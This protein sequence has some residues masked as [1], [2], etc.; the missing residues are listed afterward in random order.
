ML[1]NTYKIPN[2]QSTTKEKPII[3][4][5]N[6][7]FQSIHHVIFAFV[8]YLYCE[9]YVF[10]TYWYVIAAFLRTLGRLTGTKLSP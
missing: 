9:K 8:L 6:K 7:G 3:Y 5:L 2:S 10:Y 1:V 4:P